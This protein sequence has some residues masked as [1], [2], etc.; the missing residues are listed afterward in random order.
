M[1]TGSTTR[2]PMSSC[3]AGAV[4][5]ARLE[6]RSAARATS[7]RARRAS[8]C[9]R[10][11]GANTRAR[12]ARRSASR[13][14]RPDGDCVRRSDASMPFASSGVRSPGAGGRGGCRPMLSIHWPVRASAY[15]LRVVRLPHRAAVRR[16]REAAD[17]HLVAN[18]PRRDRDRGAGEHERGDERGR[19]GARQTPGEVQRAEDRHEDEARVAEHRE[20]RDD[21]EQHGA[22][23]R[24]G[25]S[26]TRSVSSTSAAAHEL[27]DDLAVDVHVVPDEI[28]IQRRD[29]GSDEA[30]TPA[31]DA[32]PIS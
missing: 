2:R 25:R 6:T 9:R 32:P 23:R 17:A 18:E 31:E 30:G 10:D 20:A 7:P 3:R 26:T 4:A 1:Y 29:R 21:S 16:E 8:P 12:D 15:V 19:A 5:A 24:V 14:T 27:V 11:G 22:S 13:G 28:R